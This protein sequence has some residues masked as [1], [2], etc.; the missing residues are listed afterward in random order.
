MSKFDI[1]EALLRKFAKLIEDAGL[2][3]IE[4]EEEGRRLRLTKQAPASVALAP[5]VAQN[6][7]APT[8][9]PDP[10]AAPT[11]NQSAAAPV[12]KEGTCLN[13]PMVGTAYASPEPGK[14]NFVNVG[15]QVRKGQTLLIIE[16]M[17]FMNQVP[18]SQDGVVK[19]ILF[20]DGE[21]VEFGQP[22]LILVD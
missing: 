16:A 19:E 15:D 1:S 6:F 3:E 21:A 12:A 7:S 14:P 4:F 5:T 9:A 13:S 10:Q 11:L 20:E 17:K 22:L 2:T 8:T 18:A